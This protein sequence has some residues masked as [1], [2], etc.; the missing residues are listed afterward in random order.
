MTPDIR[1]YLYRLIPFSLLFLLY[2]FLTFPCIYWG[3]SGEFSY[4]ATFLGIPHPTGYPLYTQLLRLFSS[5]P[6]GSPYFLHNLLS[7]L[8]AVLAMVLLFKICLQLT[9][10][11]T[12]SW[13]ATFFFALSPTF[14][15]RTGLAEVYT[16]QV[17]I[18]LLVATM[19][20]SLLREW[21]IRRFWIISFLLGL[22]LSHHLITVMVFPGVLFLI[23]VAPRGSK[24]FKLFLGSAL[25]GLLGLL[26]YL[27][28]AFRSRFSPEFSYPNLFGI[29]LSSFRDWYWLLS[30]EIFRTEM[31]SFS[32]SRHVEDFG[33]FFFLLFKDFYWIGGIIGLLG[34]VKEVQKHTRPFIFLG[35][36]FFV[37]SISLIHYNV[38]DVFEFYIMAFSL[39]TPWLAVGLNQIGI[40][41][42][43][44]FKENKKISIY[45]SRSLYV[46]LLIPIWGVF[47]FFKPVSLDQTPLAYVHKVFSL[48]QT[49]FTLFTTYTGRDIF[50]LFQ[51]LT[52]V[53]PDVTV[54]D[55]G[56]DL[57]TE[58]SRMMKTDD[59]RSETFNNRLHLNDT[60]IMEKSLAEEI[61][62]RPVFFSREEWFLNDKFFQKKIFES[63][64]SL[65]IKPSPSILEGLPPQVQQ[66]DLLFGSSLRLLAYA[67]DPTPVVEGELF[68]IRL[69]WQKVGPI[70]GDITA[71][72][73]ME[74][75]SVVNPDSPLD[76]FFVQLTL[77]YGLWSPVLWPDGKIIE[78]IYQITAPSLHPNQYKISLTLYD[79][80]TFDQTPFKKI[81]K[82]FSLLGE[83]KIV[84]NP[85]LKHYWDN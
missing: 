82:S 34:L 38:P 18:C 57:L 65:T 71:L 62:K 67:L 66:S 21:D 80:K 26:P 27:F 33:F 83:A 54:I 6:I 7:A 84:D 17:F 13:I 51:F 76:Q 73:L 50:R 2:G 15:N 47:Q 45:Y 42:K 5:I 36:L 63:F 69:Y 28:I 53:R 40:L 72:L 56:L 81:P 12:A 49:N 30:G 8:F 32:L 11:P 24:N 79:K 37:Q 1:T 9:E 29:T 55:Y 31:S 10:N 39:W 59:P 75:K 35:L 60:R 20:L 41:L 78:E 19:G 16:M 43:E 14:L 22:G 46:L 52:P 48:P 64:N 70:S 77:G 44:T 58:R 68:A 25:F 85:D 23:V 3:D 61:S 74:N 4:V